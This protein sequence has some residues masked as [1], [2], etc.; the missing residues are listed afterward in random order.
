M[1]WLCPVYVLAC[2]ITCGY[3]AT[4][5]H[6]RHRADRLLNITGLRQP[7]YVLACTITCGYAATFQ[8]ARHRA[9]RLLNITG[10]RQPGTMGCIVVG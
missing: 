5:Q 1:V 9:D 3:A 2:T 7:V 8:H 6:A 4:L 10:L